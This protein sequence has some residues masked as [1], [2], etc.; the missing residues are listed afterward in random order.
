MSM[1]AW[2]VRHGVVGMMEQGVALPVDWKQEDLTKLGEKVG[3]VMDSLVAAVPVGCRV[4]GIKVVPVSKTKEE[5]GRLRGWMVV[6]VCSGFGPWVWWV[7]RCAAREQAARRA[8][9]EDAAKSVAG[10]S[11]ISAKACG[12]TPVDFQKGVSDG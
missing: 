2:M 6:C 7:K 4:E 8:A 11:D 12:I 10:M 3:K 5:G 1:K 9:I